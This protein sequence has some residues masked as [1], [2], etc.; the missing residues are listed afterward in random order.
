MSISCIG[1]DDQEEEEEGPLIMEEDSQYWKLY[2][3]RRG[4]YQH[5]PEGKSMDPATYSP[6]H[7]RY[8]GTLMINNN[9]LT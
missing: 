5:E 3:S 1:N 8:I 6:A 2:I 7:P 9:N 4:L